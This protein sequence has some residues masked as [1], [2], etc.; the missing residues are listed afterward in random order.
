MASLFETI[1]LW[2]DGQN[3]LNARNAAERPTLQ[4]VV[5]RLVVQLRRYGSL[6]ELAAYFYSEEGSNRCRR[7]AE[8]FFL[9]SEDCDLVCSAAHWQRF[10]EI[11]H[12]E[13]LKS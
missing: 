12:P 2:A 5:D 3:G 13:D 11:R 1:K 10:M 6:E 8:E 4:S 7:I 9:V